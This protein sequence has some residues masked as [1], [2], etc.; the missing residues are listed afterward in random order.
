MPG[1]F[2]RKMTDEAYYL[3][4]ANRPLPKNKFSKYRGV[5]KNNNPAKPYRVC[6]KHKG[7][8]YYVGAYV[9]EEDAAKAYNKAALKIIGAHAVLNEIPH[10]VH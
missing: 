5:N 8:N 7:I 9:N 10:E 3:S 4:M 6:F 2:R 1:Y